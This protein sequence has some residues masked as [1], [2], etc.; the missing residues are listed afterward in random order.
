MGDAAPV[1]VAGTENFHVLTRYNQSAYYAFAVIDLGRAV[2]RAWVTTP[3]RPASSPA[4]DPA[5]S[6]APAPAVAASAP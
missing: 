1:Y 4:V 5:A 2:R 3:A 6:A